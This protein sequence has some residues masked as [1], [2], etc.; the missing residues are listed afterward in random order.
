[1]QIRRVHPAGLPGVSTNS[2]ADGFVVDFEGALHPTHIHHL[3]SYRLTRPVS[4][5]VAYQ[6]VGELST[7]DC[8]SNVPR[9]LCFTPR[10][11][12][13]AASRFRFHFQQHRA[14]RTAGSRPTH[15]QTPILPEF[16]SRPSA[17]S[18]FECLGN[19]SMH[20]LTHTVREIANIKPS[21]I[22]V[23]VL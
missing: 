19:A 10:C 18:L 1:M 15:P 12:D 5:G 4:L 7:N 2:N 14:N 23:S 13:E 8:L 21:S 22:A 20:T 3:V 6:R 17:M 9:I 11:A 16:S